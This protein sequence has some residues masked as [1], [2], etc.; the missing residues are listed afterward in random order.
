MSIWRVS[1]LLKGTSIEVLAPSP[2]TRTPFMFC[3]QWGLSQKPSA[4]QVP[5]PCTV[6]HL[7]ILLITY[8]IIPDETLL[9]I[10]I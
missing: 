1:T 7:A 8:I 10:I 4:S 6:I 5:P 3:S 9:V 2:G